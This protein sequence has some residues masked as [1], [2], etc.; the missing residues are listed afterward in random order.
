MK[1]KFNDYIISQQHLHDVIRDNNITRKRL[2]HRH[3][4]KTTRGI[5][6][7]NNITRKRLSHRNYNNY[8]LHAYNIENIKRDKKV[9]NRTKKKKIYKI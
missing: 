7:D 2:S 5:A 3:F 6:R 4:P 1:E 8:F 9:S